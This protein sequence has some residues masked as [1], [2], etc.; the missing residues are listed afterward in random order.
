[1][2]KVKI[3][4]KST[5]VD[6]TA[7][8]DVAFLLLTFFI[9]ATKQKPPEVLSVNPP[10]S[11]STKAAPDKSIMITM[12]AEGK[13]FLAL[14]D[15]TKK[16]EVIDKF[17]AQKG[18]QL[19]VGEL[20]KLK[21][22]EFIGLPANQIKAELNLATPIPPDKLP[23]IPVDSAHNELADWMRSVTDAYKGTDQKELEKMLLV[24][25]DNNALYPVFKQVKQAFKRNDIYKFRIVTNSKDIPKG[26]ELSKVPAAE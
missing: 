4:R 22:V 26:S 6:M 9:L 1:M 21:K 13:V 14:G 16:S 5:N 2:P 15:D 3:P 18:L 12:T 19:T 11:V 23:G 7:M 24:K 20:A 10:S 8:C 25:G 17:V